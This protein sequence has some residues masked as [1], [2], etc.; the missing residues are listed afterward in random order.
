MTHVGNAVSACFTGDHI[1][2]LT[3]LMAG[4]NDIVK[5]TGGKPPF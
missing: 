1:T 4:E 3:E 2:L 5:L